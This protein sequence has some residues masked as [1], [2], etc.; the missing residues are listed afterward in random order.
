MLNTSLWF[1][2]FLKQL[3]SL[4]KLTILESESKEVDSG[5]YE[6]KF[7]DDADI[8]SLKKE[9]NVFAEN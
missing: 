1:L 5:D 6:K 2:R 3:C 9:V 8:F 4:A 7:W